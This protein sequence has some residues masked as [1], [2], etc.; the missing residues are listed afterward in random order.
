MSQRHH[1]GQPLRQA[2][3]RLRAK[4]TKTDRL[5]VAKLLTMLIRYDYGEKK[6]WSLVHV[7]SPEAENKRHLHRQL[8]T[9][10]VDRTRHI[11]RIKGLL[12]G[13]NESQE[14]GIDKSGNCPIRAM[15]VEIAWGWLRYQPNSEL[16]HWY[17]RHFGQGSKRIRKIGIVALAR[18]PSA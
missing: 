17:Q 11:K 7:P 8:A 10:K 18:K 12:A 13:Q 6:V 5:D 4:R 1:R 2:Q 9:R 15:A 16:S 14:Q 3:G